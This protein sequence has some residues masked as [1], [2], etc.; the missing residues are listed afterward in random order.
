M[1]ATQKT[2]PSE[3]PDGVSETVDLGRYC[4]GWSAWHQSPKSANFISS[5]LEHDNFDQKL[6]TLIAEL[7]SV[8]WESETTTRWRPHVIE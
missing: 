3:L 4:T 2:P 7:G 8:D 6:A 1:L 5:A